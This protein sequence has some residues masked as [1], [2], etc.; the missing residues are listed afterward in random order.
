MYSLN[1]DICIIVPGNSYTNVLVLFCLPCS[2]HALFTFLTNGS[3]VTETLH[4]EELQ[5]KTHLL[6]NIIKN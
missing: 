5:D 1:N 4:L 3:K 6:G 2:E